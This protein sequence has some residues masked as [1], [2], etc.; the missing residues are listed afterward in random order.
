MVNPQRILPATVE[1]VDIAGLVKGA[2]KGEGLGNQILRNIR[3]TDAILQVLRCFKD[4]N[5]VR[6]DGSIDRIR[7]KVTIDMELQLKDLETVDKKLEKVKLAA[8]TG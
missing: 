4:D 5:I 2:S 7:D 3:K 6:V 8:K 1:I